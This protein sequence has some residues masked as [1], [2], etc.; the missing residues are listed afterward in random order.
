MRY[1]KQ[2]I[3]TI[4]EKEILRQ[5]QIFYVAPRIKDLESIRKNLINLMPELKYEIIHGKLSNKQIEHSYERFF[6]KKSSLLI[7]T[8]MIESGLDVSNVNTII[9]EKPYLFGLSQL[10]QLRGRVGRSS[11]QAYAYLIID[12]FRKASRKFFKKLQIISKINSLGS[13]LSVASNDLDLRGGGNIVGE[14]QSG[15]IKE[16]GIELYYKML[17]ETVH[18]LKN[19]EKI[20]DDWS[21][22]IRLGFSISIPEEYIKDI[23]VRLN[24]YKRISKIKNIEDLKE[25]LEGLRDRFGKVPLSFK[26][27]FQILEIK[28][29]AKKA[30]IS[31]IDYNKGFVLEFKTDKMDK[32]ENI[33]KLVK[34][35]ASFLK[36]LPNSKIFYKN[37]NVEDIDRINGL[38]NLLS[39]ML[40]VNE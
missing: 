35:N 18:E 40:R 4:I 24:L 16:V 32:V 6:N 17:R 21:P 38:K 39:I 19:T 30:N 25:V 11:R 29:M 2:Q 31:K 26:N 8:A 14:E 10:Y 9:I 3:K 27:L 37:E 28:I 15:H 33:I 23:D 1:E 7:S 20:E 13:G 22:I 12:D 34:N 36:F 5:G